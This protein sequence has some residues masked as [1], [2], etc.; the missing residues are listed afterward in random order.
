MSAPPDNRSWATLVWRG[1]LVCVVLKVATWCLGYA[2]ACTVTF[3]RREYFGNYGHYL[4]DT[5]AVGPRKPS[6]FTA[7]ST[8][9]ADSGASRKIRSAPAPA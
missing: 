7:C 9:S 6:F 5:R 3:D 8:C 2:L 4:L 1:V